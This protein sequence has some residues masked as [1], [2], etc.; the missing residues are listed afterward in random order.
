ML[1]LGVVRRAGPVRR[2]DHRDPLAVIEGQLLVIESGVRAIT[3]L[4]AGHV[5]PIDVP[6]VPEPRRIAILLRLGDEPDRDAALGGG[7]DRVGV[8]PVGDAID[9]HVDLLRLRVVQVHRALRERLKGRKVELRVLRENPVAPRQRAGHVRVVGVARRVDP[10]IVELRP[11][12][13]DHRR[14]AGE[15][16]RLV[17]VVRVGRADEHPRIAAEVGAAELDEVLPGEQHHLEVQDA[18]GDLFTHRNAGSLEFGEARGVARRRGVGLRIH[19]DPHRHTRL[20]ALDDLV[21]DPRVFHE[22]EGDI[23][24]LGLGAD[25]VDQYLTAILERGITQAL[26]LGV[27][28]RGKERQ[29]QGR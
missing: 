16:D 8:P 9:D 22:P 27:R 3:D 15:V 25:V 1:V 10:E 11:E 29:Q 6:R 13:V 26:D 17:D 14:V 5:Q 18:A 23:E 19:E 21:G 2:P 12:A 20:E 7:D 28:S 4:D 24:P